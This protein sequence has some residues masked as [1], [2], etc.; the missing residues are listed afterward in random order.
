MSRVDALAKLIELLENHVQYDEY[1][2]HYDDDYSTDVK[3]ETKQEALTMIDQL[4][5]GAMD[6]ETI[7]VWLK[8]LVVRY[9]LRARSASFNDDEPESDYSRDLAGK[10]E[11]VFMKLFPEVTRKSI[12]EEVRDIRAREEYDSESYHDSPP[13]DEDEDEDD[14][15]VEFDECDQEEMAE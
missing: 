1:G 7:R 2:D 8:S 6:D 10:L 13:D 9:R 11:E 12:D 4:K 14:D 15:F 3:R 5:K